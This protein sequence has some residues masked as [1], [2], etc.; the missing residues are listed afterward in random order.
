[1]PQ[2]LTRPPLAL[3]QG[4]TV[5]WYFDE[6][7]FAPADGWSLLYAFEGPSTLNVA[8]TVEGTRFRVDLSGAQTSP[9]GVGAYLWQA[10]AS[11]STPTVER[12]QVGAGAL[13]VFLDLQASTAT[14]QQKTHAR[15]MLEAIEAQLEG[16]ASDGQKSMSINGRS[17]DRHTLAELM[18]ARRIYLAEVR[19]E[20]AATAQGATP[21]KRRRIK[22]RF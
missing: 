15:R 14:G 1:M 3:V 20:D 16:R 5:A 2:P 10:F 8:A 13:E 21:G 7:G 9:L 4:T 11:R 18:D 17:L 19:A 6:A 22:V 12:V